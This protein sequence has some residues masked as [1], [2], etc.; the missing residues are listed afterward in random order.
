[1]QNKSHPIKEQI[2][3]KLQKNLSHC[4]IFE[5]DYEGHDMN[6]GNEIYLKNIQMF[7][8]SSEMDLGDIKICRWAAH[9]AQ[10]CALDVTKDTEIK[11]FYLAA[12]T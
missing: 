9:T 10:L 4:S 6:D 3:S 11:T 1:M 12:E 8:D 7:E 5:D 2:W